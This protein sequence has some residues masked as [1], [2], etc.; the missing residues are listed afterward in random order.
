[1]VLESTEFLY[2]FYIHMHGAVNFVCGEK[3]CAMHEA[4]YVLKRGAVGNFK[5]LIPVSDT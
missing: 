1:M 5:F 2:S 4:N 3:D